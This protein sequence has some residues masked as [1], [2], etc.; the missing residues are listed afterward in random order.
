MDLN[1]LRAFVRVAELGSFTRASE[2][3]G[4]SKSRASLRVQALEAELG[5]QLLSRSTRTVRLTADGQQLLARAQRLLREADEVSAL[6]QASRQLRGTV[7]MDAPITMTREVIIPRLPELVSAHPQLQLLL[8]AT[9]RRVDLLRDGFDCVL[10]VGQ[11]HDSGLIAR[12]LGELSVISCASPAYLAKHGTPRS[13]ADLENHWL[14][15]YSIRLGDESARFEHRQGERDVELPMRS[16][17]TVNNTDAY[18][19]AC[20]AGLGI[21]QVPRVG[22]RDALASGALVE[23]LPELRNAPMPV[24]LLYTR[25]APKR[26]RV[27]MSWLSEVLST[28]L[29]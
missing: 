18:R 23:V 11:V 6:F 5:T 28:Y 7:R 21:I 2:Q 15:N 19:A 10:R 17:V 1:D 12:K 22:V 4:L 13:V 14:V 8:S 16:L 26:V 9:D 20:L 3:L 25:G 24:S 27:V 29:V